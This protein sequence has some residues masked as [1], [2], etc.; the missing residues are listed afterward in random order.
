M[1]HTKLGTAPGSLG[2]STESNPRAGAVCSVRLGASGG[3]GP[4]V[5]GGARDSAAVECHVC[6]QSTVAILIHL[7]C[8]IPGD[9]YRSSPSHP[10]WEISPA[11]FSSPGPLLPA[12]SL[13]RSHPSFHSPVPDTL[14]GVGGKWSYKKLKKP[15]AQSAQ[16]LSKMTPGPRAS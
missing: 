15:L 13:V 8:C 2:F 3:Q 14:L 6:P 11:T 1:S 5:P 12:G 16:T 9:R 10:A 7:P 4:A